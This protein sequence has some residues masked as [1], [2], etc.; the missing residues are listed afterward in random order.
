MNRVLMIA[1]HFPP[2]AGSSG[3]QRTLRFCRHLPDQGWEPIVLT[4]HPR[5]YERCSDDQLQD[6]PQGIEVVR[7]P[8]WDSAR[9]FAVAGRY[10]AFL[11]RP[12]RWL[13]WWFGA[14]PAGLGIIRRMKPDAIWSTYPIPTAHRIGATLARS[15]GLPWVADFRDPMAQPDYPRDPK[16]WASFAHIEKDAVLAA[17]FST[18]TTPTA[19][20]LYQERYP[21]RADNIVL[22]E[23]GYDEETFSSPSSAGTLVQDKLTLLHSGIVYPRE[24]DPRKL[25]EALALIRRDSPA[26]AAKLNLRF[27]A[28]V[29]DALL[30]RLASEFDVLDMMEIAPPIAYREALAE[31]LGAD[32]LLILQAA[33]CNAQVPAKLY[34]YF[35]ARRPVIALTDPAGDTADVARRAGVEAIAPLDDA[36]AI[37][38]LVKRF[39]E[40]ARIGMLPTDTAIAG[41]SRQSRT[42]ELARML[43]QC[44]A[45]KAFI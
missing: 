39:A 20:R 17:R 13:S 7:A 4:A 23:N 36:V 25:F 44:H 2:L 26:I 12:D 37:A 34:E 30:Q 41:A 18:F 29:H 31:M 28:P 22:L 14:V 1:F 42:V 6:I 43:S 24:R 21:T 5:A 38:A 11:T 19:T 3:I 10:P 40:G 16:T 8:A 32:G 15:S 9:H 35:R 33:N 45:E 27:R